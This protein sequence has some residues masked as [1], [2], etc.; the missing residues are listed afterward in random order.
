[1]FPANLSLR[2]SLA[3]EDVPTEQVGPVPGVPRL[4]A[5]Q[6]LHIVPMLDA[7]CV[8]LLRGAGAYLPAYWGGRHLGRNSYSAKATLSLPSVPSTALG[9][10]TIL[11]S[12]Y[13]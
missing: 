13:G 1:M 11:L 9:V 7:D 3:N 10:G 2:V 12:F 6:R 5:C 8:W 4:S